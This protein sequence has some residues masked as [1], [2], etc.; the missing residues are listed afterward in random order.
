MFENTA[1]PEPTF[2]LAAAVVAAPELVCVAI[3]VAPTDLA[4]VYARHARL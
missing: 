1:L 4:A 3:G 2:E